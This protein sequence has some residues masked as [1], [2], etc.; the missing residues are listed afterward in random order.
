MKKITAAILSL[1]I[2]AGMTACKE[3]KAADGAPAESKSTASANTAEERPNEAFSD[4]ESS[5]SVADSES[6]DTEGSPEDSSVPDDEVILDE[7]GEP[8]FID[9]SELDP[10]LTEKIYALLNAASNGDKDT[11]LKLSDLTE[12][13][14]V[15]DRMVDEEALIDNY[16]E[17]HKYFDGGFRDKLWQ[18]SSQKSES[19]SADG[20]DV[21]YMSFFAKGKD[22]DLWIWCDAYDHNG[23]W[24]VKPKLFSI[25][26]NAYYDYEELIIQQM[27]AAAAGD[28]DKYT[29]Y[30]N[31]D[32]LKEVFKQLYPD[33]AEYLDDDETGETD[34]ELEEVMFSYEELNKAL[35]KDFDGKILQVQVFELLD[36]EELDGQDAEI[37][38]RFVITVRNSDGKFMEVEGVAY[39]FGG[40]KGVWL[41]PD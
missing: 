38:D 30:L 37:S 11:Y 8:L 14:A 12:L 9:E 7:N 23:K 17:L 21:Y 15:S 36:I 19:D 5:E 1:I 20:C 31:L 3:N 22:A 27:K 35:G 40:E 4:G 32:I 2:A 25:V 29:E 24:I 6:S 18:I 34:E 13:F 39:A 10:A 41:Q 26:E 33:S 28:S 16:E